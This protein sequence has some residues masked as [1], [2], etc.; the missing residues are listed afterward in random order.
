[1]L[2]QRSTYILQFRTLQN[3][4]KD[5]AFCKTILSVLKNP[6]SVNHR[7][8]SMF[9]ILKNE[10]L[11]RLVVRDGRPYLLLVVP[12][13]IWPQLLIEAHDSLVSGHL[14]VARTYAR[15]KNRYYYPSSLESVS[16]YVAS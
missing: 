12:K 5:H 9:Y 3:T 13:S 16:T 4:S 6:E 1:M 2:S 7:T 10:I 15:I 14:G 11:F 8:R